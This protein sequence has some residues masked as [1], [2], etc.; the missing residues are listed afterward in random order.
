MLVQ[1]GRIGRAHGIRGGV[2]VQVT[3]DDP[4]DRFAVGSV[5]VT[6][7]VATGPLT[8]RAVR[9]DPPVAVVTF[10]GVDD[11]TAAEG[12]RGTALLVDTDALTRPQDADEYYD[13]Q[14]VGLHVRDTAGRELGVVE[15]VLHLPASPVLQVARP[16]GADAELVPFV[17]ALVPTVDLDGGF[18]VVDPPEGMFA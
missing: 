5:L 10:E 14:L 7:P 9:F 8:V 18:L 15:D 13:H 16:E 17:T 4:Q 12:L 1:V 3:T 11:R 2:V 6:D